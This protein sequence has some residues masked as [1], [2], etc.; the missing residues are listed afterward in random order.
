LIH[1]AF[2]PLLAALVD[3]GSGSEMCVLAQADFKTI[4]LHAKGTPDVNLDEG[5]KSAYCTYTSKSGAHGGIELD[6][7]Y[8]AGDSATDVEQTFK[9]V[10][11]ED[12]AKYVPIDIPGAS[13]AAICLAI[14]QA[15]YKPFAAVDVRRGDLVFSI[16]LPS[17]PQAQKQLV[18]LS[19]LVLS[20]LK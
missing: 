9:T 8:P 13:E 4:G 7:F 6:V 3:K 16:S 2:A 18:E 1:L 5:G 15:G 14:P 10:M 20:R 11:N 19:K 17:G 12:P